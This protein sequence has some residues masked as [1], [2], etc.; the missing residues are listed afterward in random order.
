MQNK[1]EKVKNFIHFIKEAWKDEQKRAIIMLIVMFL[2]FSFVV[3]SVRT[4]N[5]SLSNQED[6]SEGDSNFDFSLSKLKSDNYH[7]IYTVT[8]DNNNAVYEGDR[9]SRKELFNI[10]GVDK[11]YRYEDTYLKDIRGVWSTIDNPIIFSEFR[12]INNIEQLLK[13]AS[14]D[15]KTEYKDNNK[16]Y[17]YNITTTTII[18]MLE[19]LDID[20]SDNPNT[21][22]IITDSNNDIV[23]INYNLSSYSIYKKLGNSATISIKYSRFGEIEEIEDPK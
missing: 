5:S 12:D 13:Q 8:I 19:K 17:N 1:K 11:Y 6:Y 20:I 7:Y 18:K 22:N 16:V 21:I 3:I 9:A 14:F 2:F 15:S 4:T 23:E 10:N